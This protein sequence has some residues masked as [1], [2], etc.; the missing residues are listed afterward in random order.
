MGAGWGTIE[1]INMPDASAPQII[2]ASVDHP[3]TTDY[4]LIVMLA[5]GMADTG[6]FNCIDVV[7]P[8]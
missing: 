6:T 3:I 4:R 1:R 2:F 5:K 7:D 8:V